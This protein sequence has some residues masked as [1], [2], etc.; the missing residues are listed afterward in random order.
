MSRSGGIVTDGDDT[1]GAQQD[2][3]LFEQYFAG[4]PLT[5]DVLPVGEGM[6]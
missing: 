5:R 6:A 3:E 4:S 1:R 2:N